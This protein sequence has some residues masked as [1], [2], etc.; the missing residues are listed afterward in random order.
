MDGLNPTHNN[1][2]EYGWIEKGEKNIKTNTG[3]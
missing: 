3:R 2:L 1:K